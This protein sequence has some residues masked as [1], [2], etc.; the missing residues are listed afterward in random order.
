MTHNVSQT[1][2]NW[3]TTGLHIPPSPSLSSLT[4]PSETVKEVE[5]HARRTYV[6]E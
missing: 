3:Q 6:G 4:K 1:E 5:N 2:K